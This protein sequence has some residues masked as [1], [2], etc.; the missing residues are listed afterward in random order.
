M[1]FLIGERC[2]VLFIFNALFT[3]QWRREKMNLVEVHATHRALKCGN[4]LHFQMPKQTM[5]KLMC[6]VFLQRL[7]LI[8]HTCSMQLVKFILYRLS[9]RSPITI[10]SPSGPLTIHSFRLNCTINPF[11]KNMLI[12][13]KITCNLDTWRALTTIEHISIPFMTLSSSKMNI[14]WSNYFRCL[15]CCPTRSHV[16]VAPEFMIR[17]HECEPCC[18][19]NV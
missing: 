7:C 19:A 9:L 16:F 11:D 8:G 18:V 1:S 5:S 4:I 12:D 6:T 2:H 15:R 10:T 17:V 14:V 3:N 13:T